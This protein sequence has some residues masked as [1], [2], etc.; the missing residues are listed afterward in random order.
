M[1]SEKSPTEHPTPQPIAGK[2][3]ELDSKTESPMNAKRTHFTVNLPVSLHR[4]FKIA[5][6]FKN[7][8]QGDEINALV[9]RSVLE[10]EKEFNILPSEE[11]EK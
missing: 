9:L 6:A 8:K 5:C 7:V 11:S 2:D 3:P 1:T 10:M 4:R